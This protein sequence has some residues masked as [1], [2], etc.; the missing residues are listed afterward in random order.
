MV[1]SQIMEVTGCY[2]KDQELDYI[3]P[4][5]A[6]LSSEMDKKKAVLYST[7][8]HFFSLQKALIFKVP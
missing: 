8:F 4:W 7:H 6:T 1:W 3:R 5:G 2:V